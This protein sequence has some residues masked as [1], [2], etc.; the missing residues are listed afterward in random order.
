MIFFML[1]F[2]A[3][4]QCFAALGLQLYRTCMHLRLFYKL[5]LCDIVLLPAFRSAHVTMQYDSGARLVSERLAERPYTVTA[6]RRL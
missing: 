3:K 6:N 5:Q 2:F 1:V 4:C